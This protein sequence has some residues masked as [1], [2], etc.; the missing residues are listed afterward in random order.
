[1]FAD[2]QQELPLIDNACSIQVQLRNGGSAN[3]GQANHQSVVI[4]PGEMLVPVVISRVKKRDGFPCEW[5]NRVCLVVLEIVT[6]LAGPR[7]VLR[8]A[9]AAGSQRNDVLVRESI[10]AIIF[11][12]NAVFAA[13]LRAFPDEQPQFFGNPPSNHEARV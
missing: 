5:I 6:S 11:L 9:F 2:K 4:T 10:R 7:Q 13:T 12:A 3:R 8:G 1:M